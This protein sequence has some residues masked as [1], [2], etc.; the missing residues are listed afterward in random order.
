M[1]YVKCRYDFIL[2]YFFIY[3]F[4]FG[5]GAEG[6]R[7]RR[8]ALTFITGICEYEAY[9]TYINK[10]KININTTCNTTCT[11]QYD[12]VKF[13]A[14]CCWILLGFTDVQPVHWDLKNLY[15]LPVSQKAALR[16]KGGLSISRAYCRQGWAA[17]QWNLFWETTA[18]RDHLSWKTI[19]PWQKII[20]FNAIEPVSPKT[21]CLETIFYCQ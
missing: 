7:S 2:F 14:E 13:H 19:Y 17:V 11:F 18:M 4:F 6:G 10:G 16:P 15:P 21:T 1:I 3:L 5:G 8:G 20:Y 9:T 12:V